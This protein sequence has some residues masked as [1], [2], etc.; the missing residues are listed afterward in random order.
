MTWSSPLVA[1]RLRGSTG[2][3]VHLWHASLAYPSWGELLPLLSEEELRR[4]DRVVFE[5][6]ARRYVV[7]HA[8]LRTVLGRIIDV[9]PEDVALDIE[10]RGRPFLRN[11]GTRLHFSLSRSNERVLIGVASRPL[12]VDIEWL[13]APIDADALAATVFSPAER[14]AFEQTRLETRQEIFLRCWTWK[15]AILKAT[16]HGL[17]IPPRAAEVLVTPSCVMRG[18]ATVVCLGSSWQVMS[19]WPQVAFV[20]AVAFAK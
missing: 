20:G 12:G 3:V 13:G 7:S 18:R 17:S 11:G 19:V 14:L 10:A 15:E 16:G 1:L 8:V 9:P 2:P 6:D 5:R 4:V